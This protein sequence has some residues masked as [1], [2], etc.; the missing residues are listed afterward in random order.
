MERERERLA[1]RETKTKREAGR[2]RLTPWDRIKLENKRKKKAREKPT[3]TEIVTAQKRPWKAETHRERELHGYETKRNRMEA[4]SHTHKGDG[5]R[6]QE[7][8][9]ARGKGSGGGQQGIV[10]PEDSLLSERPQGLGFPT[11]R[12]PRTGGGPR[13]LSHPMWEPAPG[14]GGVILPVWTL[15]WVHGSISHPSLVL[16]DKPPSPKQGSYPDQGRGCQGFS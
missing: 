3:C 5:L 11:T 13:P 16:W 6:E 7:T 2:K 9:K 8:R 15:P 12:R 4:C 10:R 14:Q 1:G